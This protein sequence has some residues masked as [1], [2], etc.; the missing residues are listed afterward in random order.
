[1][2]KYE[3]LHDFLAL[4]HPTQQKVT[5]SFHQIEFIIGDTLPKAASEH[6]PWWGNQRDHENRPQAKAWMSAGY[7]VGEVSLSQGGIVRFRR[8]T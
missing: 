7:E 1:M 2:P 4:S 5:L 8:V 6:R 3:P